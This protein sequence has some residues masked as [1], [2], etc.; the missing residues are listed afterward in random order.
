[1]DLIWRSKFG[2]RGRIQTG[3]LKATVCSAELCSTSTDVS[4]VSFPIQVPPLLELK[5]TVLEAPGSIQ[6]EEP[7][8]VTCR[9]TNTT[10]SFV[11]LPTPL[12]IVIITVCCRNR[13]MRLRSLLEKLPDGGLLWSGTTGKVHGVLAGD[14]SM[15][16]KFSLIP[17][18]P[19]LQVLF[20][21]MIQYT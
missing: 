15:E 3:Q 16:L 14:S 9:I 18:R 10:Y 11:V 17:V 6:L 20:V 1:M 12:F 7:F 19:G 2:D 8:T 13:P 5:L 4:A 21:L